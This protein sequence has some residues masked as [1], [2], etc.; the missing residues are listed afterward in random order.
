MLFKDK[1]LIKTNK[2]M[3]GCNFLM[4][5]SVINPRFKGTSN[6]FRVL[7]D[8]YLG[9]NTYSLVL[10]KFHY[11]KA[12]PTFTGKE[13]FLT[14]NQLT[15]NRPALSI[16]ISERIAKY[17]DLKN[18]VS[19]DNAFDFT[20]LHYG[21]EGSTLFQKRVQEPSIISIKDNEGNNN[22]F[23]HQHNEGHP[24][25]T[26]EEPIF[27][28][29]SKPIFNT[30]PCCTVTLVEVYNLITSNAFGV[31]TKMLRSIN[32]HNES[33]K[34]KST[35]FDFVTFSGIFSMRSENNLIRHSGLIVLDFDHVH[36]LSGMKELLL[37]DPFFDT[38]LLFISP[39][40]DG[41]KWIVSI[42]LTLAK[43]QNYFRAIANYLQ[44]TYKLEVDQSG[45]DISRACFLPYDP[46][47]YINPKRLN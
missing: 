7:S 37:N 1:F 9:L 32:N 8:S 34:F 13:C 43:H 17:K 33:R 38:E 19:N 23:E 46:N 24:L 30:Q 5:T 26:K 11:K 42:D 10:R 14:N 40:G 27:S 36:D 39:S 45:K 44:T 6:E 18:A 21:F 16:S 35:N 47:A 12:V 25:F 15:P 20:S 4:D 41:L 28:Y 31:K 22:P 29:F 2:L 3:S